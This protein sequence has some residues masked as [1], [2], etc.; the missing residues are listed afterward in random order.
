MMKR[1]TK[2]WRVDVISRTQD[3]L[4]LFNLFPISRSL[5]ALLQLGTCC[6]PIETPYDSTS[7]LPRPYNPV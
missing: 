7:F 2:G 1:K 6:I 5:Q 4:L 3:L